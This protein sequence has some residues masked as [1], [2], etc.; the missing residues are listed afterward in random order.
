[1]PLV[2][3][4]LGMTGRRIKD[5]F[6]RWSTSSQHQENVEMARPGDEIAP[7]PAVGVSAGGPVRPVDIF[8]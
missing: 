5:W 2:W 8:I 3:E 1:M 7:G 4:S 6:W